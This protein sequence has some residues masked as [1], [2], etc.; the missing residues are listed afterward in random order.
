MG[1][2]DYLIRRR[3]QSLDDRLL[4][5]EA[6]GGGVPA[7][8]SIT[9]AKLSFDPATQTELDA[10]AGGLGS[11]NTQTADY[12]LVLADAGKV[13]EV[14]S[15]SAK[16]LTVPTNASVAFPIGTII[17]IARI[18][19]GSVT[20]HQVSGTVVIRNRVDTAGT[21]DRTIASQYSAASL[22]KR[23]TDEWVLV[24]DIA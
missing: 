10:V 6:G 24:G 3:V 18:G 7:D 17:E 5:V 8:G 12:T 13:V 20:I 11:P 2:I 23:A 16:I 19:A 15:A 14:N 21:A 9:P 22:R 1:V 4:V